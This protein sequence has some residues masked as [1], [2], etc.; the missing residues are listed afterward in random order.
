MQILLHISTGGY[1]LPVYS[2]KYC[3]NAKYFDFCVVSRI[4]ASYFCLYTNNA[5]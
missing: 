3:S 4:P 2:L 5:C 1:L